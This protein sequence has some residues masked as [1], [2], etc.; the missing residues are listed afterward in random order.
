LEIHGA[1]RHLPRFHRLQL[2][3]ISS[4]DE[5]KKREKVSVQ[6][7]RPACHQRRIEE[8]EDLGGNEFDWIHSQPG[9]DD[10]ST[11][12]ILDHFDSSTNEIQLV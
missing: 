2:K 9:I 6:S 12:F 8:E 3:T 7:P 11:K 5:R 10:D 1:C 4:A